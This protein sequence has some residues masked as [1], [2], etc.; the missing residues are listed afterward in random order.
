MSGE[1]TSREVDL[2]SLIIPLYLPTLFIMFGWGMILPVLP[3]FARSLAAGLGLTGVIVSMRGAGSLLF[4]LPAGAIISR[5]RRFPVL[6]F[7]AIGASL[8][9]IATGFAG[10]LVSLALLTIAMGAVHVMWVLSVQTHLRQNLPVYRRGRA[11]ALL[12]G[13]SR[14]GWMLGPIVGG[15]IGKIY[16]LQSVYFG[17]A[18]IC[19]FAVLF[20]LIGSAYI[21]FS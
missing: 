4:D 9:A 1:T 21:H 17:Q 5:V 12:G 18:V 15:Y 16:G 11:M 20:L 2:A 8:V 3:L 7:A 19:L 10:S 6:L 14:I 13:T